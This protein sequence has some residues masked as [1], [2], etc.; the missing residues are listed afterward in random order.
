MSKTY[1]RM[2]EITEERGLDPLA[3]RAR[4]LRRDKKR[5]QDA[6]ERS[7]A[8]DARRATMTP[9]QIR[10][11]LE[12]DTRRVFGRVPRAEADPRGVQ[13]R[14]R[15]RQQSDSTEETGMN[16]IY[17]RM[18]EL[19]YEG[20]FG[21]MNLPGGKKLEKWLKQKPLTPEEIKKG[22]ARVF[23]RNATQHASGVKQPKPGTAAS[24]RAD[25]ERSKALDKVIADR[26][27]RRKALEK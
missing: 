7:R 2:A 15:A 20:V 4:A 18:A 11:G 24:A 13:A 5:Q 12:D 8:L 14:L 9:A 22:R 16:K 6:L 19:L 27:R 21:D 3:V 26:E 17:E 23:A 10:Q 1:E 25:M